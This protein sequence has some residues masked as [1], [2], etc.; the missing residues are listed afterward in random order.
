[1]ST[2][3]VTKDNGDKTG[4]MLIDQSET[5]VKLQVSQGPEGFAYGP[6]SPRDHGRYG[7]APLVDIWPNTEK[8]L[9]LD[10]LALFAG[11]LFLKFSIAIYHY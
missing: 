11:V 10:L 9:L 3:D 6:D 8:K 2:E 4:Q 1:M 5:I 7:D